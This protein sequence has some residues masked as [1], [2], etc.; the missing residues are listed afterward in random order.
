VDLDI[1]L[2]HGFLV[3]L[4][5][6]LVRW[7][8]MVEPS[9]QEAHI[10]HAHWFK[11][12]PG[13]KQDNYWYG[14]HSWIFGTGDELTRGD[15]QPRSAAN[16]PKGVM[17]GQYFDAGPQNLIY[18]LHNKTASPLVAY[19]VL[20]ATFIHGSRAELEPIL[21]RPIHE[22]SGILFGRT[23]NV[24]RQPNG[25]GLYETSI[26]YKDAPD[27]R[28]RKGPIR[29]TSTVDG[30]IVGMGGHLHPGGLRVVVNNLG[31]KDHPCTDD[32]TTP[33]GGTQLFTSRSRVRF[34]PWSEG[35]QMEVTDPGFRAPIHKG[36][37][38][39][40]TG[41]Y[42]N[43]FHAW[44]DV[45]THLGIYVDEQQPPGAGCRPQIVDRPKADPHQGVLSKPWGPVH[46]H[47]CGIR[48]GFGYCDKPIKGDMT[49]VHQNVV[50][51][52]NFSYQPGDFSS[53]VFGQTPWI[54]Q[55]EQ[56]TFINDDQPMAIRHS[57]TTCAWPCN[58]EYVANYPLADGRWDSVTLGYDP[59]DGGSPNPVSRTP[60]D[61][62]P[63]TYTYFCR[64]HP[65]MRG[66]F[67]VLK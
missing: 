41:V 32:G 24:P 5:P 67:K 6:H 2:R 54:R 53:G 63:G 13:N 49:L 58:G 35:F 48:W 29:W 28:L 55:G 30:T 56:L 34:A 51:I 8:D 7:P 18:M 16:G 57:V 10:H 66:V 25:D 60:K 38:I 46:D 20:D 42:E 40:I 15:F 33:Y 62:A 65:W 26:D 44:Y 12:D 14:T 45:M 9:H 11:P 22:V 17:Y 37:V 43:K 36:D 4:E 39:Q 19:V 21:H 61:L 31:S 64:I 23:Y 27:P 52:T 47:I 1:P 3:T 59:I 50:H